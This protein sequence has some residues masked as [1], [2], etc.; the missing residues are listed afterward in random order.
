MYRPNDRACDDRNYYQGDKC[1]S[2]CF[3]HL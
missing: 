3:S 2:Y 1:E